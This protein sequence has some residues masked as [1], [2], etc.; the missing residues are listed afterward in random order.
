MVQSGVRRSSLAMASMVSTLPTRERMDM[1]A[2]TAPRIARFNCSMVKSYVI[3][4]TILTN[5]RSRRGAALRISIPKYSSRMQYACM[6]F[7]NP[8]FGELGK[9]KL[10]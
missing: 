1:A 10:A 5:E 7:V 3:H 9:K 2:R 4:A 8:S 6:R